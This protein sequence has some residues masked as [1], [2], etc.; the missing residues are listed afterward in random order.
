MRTSGPRA[1]DAKRVTHTVRMC[2]SAPV[3]L[4][5]P[6]A[7]RDGREKCAHSASR[8]KNEVQVREK[9]KI[10]PLLRTRVLQTDDSVATAEIFAV[11]QKRKKREE[12]KRAESLSLQFFLLRRTHVDAEREKEPSP[13][14]MKR[15]A[16]SGCTCRGTQK[17]PFLSFNAT[18][19]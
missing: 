13:V 3:S 19:R 1:K 14:T 11:L 16:S 18:I 10:F 6:F 2:V 12:K 15:G 4:F 5:P 8:R 9:G 17:N 7:T